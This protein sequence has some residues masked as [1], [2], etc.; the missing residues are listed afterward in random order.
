[1]TSAYTVKAHFVDERGHE[2]D[3]WGAFGPFERAGD[4]ERCIQTLCGKPN[5][6][7]VE[8]VKTIKP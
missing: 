6:T 3:W 1:M 2:G 8:I 4:A 5:V 7:S